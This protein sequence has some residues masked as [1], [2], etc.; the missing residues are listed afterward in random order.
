[1]KPFSI[2]SS[3]LMVGSSQERPIAEIE[4]EIAMGLADEVEHGQAFLLLEKAKPAPKL[5][6]EYREAL[7]RPQKQDGVDLGD[8][9]AFVVEIDYEQEIHSPVA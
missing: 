3:S 1:M 2:C 8:V 5:L 9:D 4:P 6:Q 7:G